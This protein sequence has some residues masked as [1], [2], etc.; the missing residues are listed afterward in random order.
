MSLVNEPG[1]NWG[2][3]AS[4]RGAG[5]GWR[6][7]RAIQGV[8]WKRCHAVPGPWEDAALAMGKSQSFPFL[9]LSLEA[10]VPCSDVS[11]VG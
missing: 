5:E 10:A 3:S 2:G 7:L 9:G 1:G 8:G 11:K 6:Q 4:P